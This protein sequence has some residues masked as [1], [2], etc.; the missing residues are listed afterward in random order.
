LPGTSTQTLTFTVSTT[1]ASNNAELVYPKIDGKHG[2]WAGAGGGAVLALLLFFGIPA[3]RR[4]WRSLI[5]TLVLMTALGEL[6]GCGGSGSSGGT[7]NSTPGTSA[8]TYTFTLTG[9][10]T[11][12]A[13]AA[14]SA[15][16]TVV[17]N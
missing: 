10:G 8:G 16:F 7:S 14:V 5:G 12:P 3:R 13:S 9:A 2:G 11:P 6:A 15:T 1:A 17:V 4:S